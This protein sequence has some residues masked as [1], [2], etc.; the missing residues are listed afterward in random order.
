M[1]TEVLDKDL[2]AEISAAREASLEAESHEPRA[3]SVHYDSDTKKII[4]HLKDDS[5]LAIEAELIQGLENATDEQRSDI[6]LEGDGYALHWET[7]DV[8]ISV[9]G[10]VKGIYG[11][12]AWMTHLG[13]KGGQAKSE[14]KSEAARANGKKGGRPPNDNPLSSVRS[15]EPSE[16]MLKKLRSDAKQKGMNLDSYLMFLSECSAFRESI[17]KDVQDVVQPLAQEVQALATSVARM[18]SHLLQP[19]LDLQTNESNNIYESYKP[20]TRDSYKN[21]IVS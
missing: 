6:E 13:Q 7:L 8:D 14:A 2:L 11:T 18:E 5:R 16:K 19:K 12:K 20:R 17:Q 3:K 1:A 10:L 9:P 4:L 15:T 21:T